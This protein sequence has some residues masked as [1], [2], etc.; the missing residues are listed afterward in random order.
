VATPTREELAEVAAL[1]GMQRALALYRLGLRTEASAEWLWNVY[2]MND[3]ALLAAAELARIN[4]IWDRA[5]NTADRT[6]AEHDFTLRYPAPYVNV[7]SKQARARKLDFD[8]LFW[9]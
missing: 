7:L 6:V 4:G 9:P 5:I 3:R 1:A 2:R 8:V